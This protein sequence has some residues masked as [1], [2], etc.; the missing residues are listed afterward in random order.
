VQCERQAAAAAK[1]ASGL[2]KCAMPM[3]HARQ[4]R[5][6]RAVV[7]H[8]AAAKRRSAGRRLQI[9][10]L[11]GRQARGVRLPRH[12]GVIHKAEAGGVG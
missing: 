11:V 12:A 3:L 2:F 9:E 10:D 6:G 5:E 7:S 4:W 8:A 1:P